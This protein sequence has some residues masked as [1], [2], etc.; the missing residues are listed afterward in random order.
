MVIYDAYLTGDVY[1][2]AIVD[3]DGQPISTSCWGFYGYSEIAENGHVVNEAKQII[4]VL[5]KD[6]KRLALPENRHD[7]LALGIP[8]VP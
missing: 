2:Y 1:G 8:S 3:P 6:A 5:V 4:N 7:Q